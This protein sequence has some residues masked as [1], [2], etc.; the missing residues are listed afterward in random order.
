MARRG[1]AQ[2]RRNPLAL[3]RCPPADCVQWQRM[4][5]WHVLAV[6]VVA[7]V[8]SAIAPLRA[9]PLPCL[10]EVSGVTWLRWEHEQD[11]LNRWCESVGPPVFASGPRRDGEISR[12]LVLSWNVHVGGADVEELMTKA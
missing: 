1:R 4:T 8:A 12:L 3:G 9:E 2:E 7:L 5:R 11:L 6:V 10:R